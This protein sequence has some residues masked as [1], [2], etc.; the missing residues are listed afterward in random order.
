MS[1]GW[2]SAGVIFSV[3]WRATRPIGLQDRHHLQ[4]AWHASGQFL[5]FVGSPQL[6]IEPG[7][8]P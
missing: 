4:M 1:S 3:D 8:N 7:S 2:A 6:M 5:G